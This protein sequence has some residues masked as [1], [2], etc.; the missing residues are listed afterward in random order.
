[1]L[2]LTTIL[3]LKLDVSQPHFP[4]NSVSKAELQ[5]GSHWAICSFLNDAAQKDI[6]YGYRNNI[7]WFQKTVSDLTELHCVI[8]NSCCEEGTPRIWFCK[9]EK[10]NTR[11]NVEKIDF[12]E[13]IFS[14]EWCCVGVCINVRLYV[15]YGDG[16]TISSVRGKRRKCCSKMHKRNSNRNLARGYSL[17]FPPLRSQFCY[18]FFLFIKNW[19]LSSKLYFFSSKIESGSLQ[20]FGATNLA[21]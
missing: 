21:A 2:L 12:W 10:W 15:T 9:F 17:T 14:S 6:N 16:H 8:G 7:L 1:M 13:F 4:R 5:P 19:S 11:W 20:G 3:W 18:P